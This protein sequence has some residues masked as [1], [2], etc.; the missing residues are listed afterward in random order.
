MS[1][2]HELMK[3]RDIAY[4]GFGFGFLFNRLIKHWIKHSPFTIRDS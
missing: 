2:S 3:T 1:Y 4:R